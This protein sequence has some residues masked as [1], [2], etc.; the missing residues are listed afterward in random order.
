[1]VGGVSVSGGAASARLAGRLRDA[2]PHGRG[3]PAEDWDRRH[4]GLVVIVWIHAL[5]VPV[6]GL[7][8]GY[9]VAHTLAESSVVAVAGVVAGIRRLGHNPRSAAV[10]I[11]LLSASALLVHF[12]GGYIEFHFHFFV[13]IALLSLYQHWLPFLLAIAYVGIHHG[14]GGAVDPS[15][16]YNHAD[17]AAHPWKWAGIHAGFVLAAATANVFA[18]RY[19]EQEQ[20]RRRDLLRVTEAALSRLP[21]PELL[22]E[23]LRR[24][25]DVLKSDT[26]TI[27][28]FD[29]HGRLVIEATRGGAP[30]EKGAILPPD[31]AIAM[32]IAQTGQPAVIEDARAEIVTNPVH[33]ERA[34]RSLAGVP[35]L[36][37]GERLGML[38]V[39]TVERRRFGASDL[40]L[41]ELAAERI[42]PAIERARLHERDHRIADILQRSL[43]PKSLPALEGVS[44]AFRYEPAGE[45]IEAGGDWYDAFALPGGRLGLVMGDV[46]GRGTEAASLMGQLRTGL[47]AY[48]MEGHSPAEILPRLSNLARELDRGNMATLLYVEVDLE[49]GAARYASAGHLPPLLVSPGGEAR[50]L[51]EGRGTPV[52]SPIEGTW[53][54]AETP[55][56][57]G[58]TLVLYTDGLV[59]SRIE[60]IDDG[61]QRLEELAGDN[62]ALD[63]EGLCQ[64]VIDRIPT[65]TIGDDVALMVVK[66]APELGPE[67]RLEYPAVP[68]SAARVRHTLERWLA[69]RG[70]A[71]EARQDIVLAA[72]EAAANAVE[73]AYG[74]AD[75]TFRLVA[76]HSDGEIEL[77]ITDSGSWRPPRDDEGR[78]LVFMNALMDAVQVDPGPAGTTVLMRK[79]VGAGTRVGPSS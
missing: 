70:T 38:D 4:R 11:G 74:P 48:A 22:D 62:A 35:L 33:R 14:V 5:A 17:G 44:L 79:R 40:T 71:I 76:R 43:L 19:F 3:L 66:L 77:A 21:L 18:W 7:A 13:M 54:E 20:A 29:E 1:M 73:H 32:R 61:F 42:A 27:S 46:V 24:I 2:V 23:V 10:S 58:A 41:L 69:E 16:V 68:E 34:V 50:Y 64:L 28:L 67:M 37:A 51:W 78:G 39:G 15:A 36:V 75:A 57:P 31:D 72:S 30:G 65:S 25:S 53:S 45:S 47:R 12:S 6:F 56:E 60:P 49:R 8:Q 59:E 55:L 26:A 52:G 63:A 9:P